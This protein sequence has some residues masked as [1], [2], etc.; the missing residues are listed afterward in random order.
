MDNAHFPEKEPLP[1]KLTAWGIWLLVVNGM[2]GAGIFG[3]PGEAARLTGIYSPFVFVFCAVLILPILLCFAELASY[4]R[5]TG[6]PVRYTGEAYGHLV[7]FETGWLFYVARMVAF[8]A[9]S[10]LLVDSVAYFWEPANQG[11][12]R[13]ALLFLVLA[14]LTWINVIGSVQA[15]RSLAVLTVMKFIP[16]VALVVFGLV[17]IGPETLPFAARPLPSAGDFGAATLLLIYAYVGFESA[18]VPAGEAK[19][20]ARD[21]PRGLIMGLAVVTLL[22]ILIQTVSVAA[23][24]QVAHSESPLLDV[25]GSLIGPVGAVLLMAGVVASVGGNMVGS[26]FSTPRLTY[27]LARDGSLPG[28]FG[29]VHPRFETPSRSIIFYGAAVFL[30]AAFG[31]FVWLAAMGV[32]VRLLMYVLSIAA[33]PRLRRRYR[34]EPGVFVLPWG[35][36]VP[37]IAVLASAFLVS[38][39]GLDS[40]VVTG[41]FILAGS[42]LYAVARRNAR[43]SANQSS[44]GGIQQRD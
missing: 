22:Y 14:G 31:S 30:L 16:L 20:P 1:R 41:A 2:I 27:I 34:N 10:N 25:A 6:G 19:N 24:P 9:N 7:G 3:T 35:Y 4:F 15:M 13:L 40:V 44:A 21:M 8:A 26:M 42:G 17:H 38:H 12:I 37:V 5:G 36:T 23:Y 18:V 29:Y 11:G 32:L 39:V 33:I 28:W 43:L